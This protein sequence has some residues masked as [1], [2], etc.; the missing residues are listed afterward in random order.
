MSIKSIRLL[1]V[2]RM[3][4]ALVNHIEDKKLYIPA[5]EKLLGAIAKSSFVEDFPT[6]FGAVLPADGTVLL[7]KRISLSPELAEEKLRLKAALKTVLEH[8]RKHP[9]FKSAKRDSALSF[10]V[11]LLEKLVHY[12]GLSNCRSIEKELAEEGSL[13]IYLFTSEDGLQA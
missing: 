8:I 9:N 2:H 10:R 3:G 13:A 11:K 5:A 7:G 6:V 1:S 12:L 4:V